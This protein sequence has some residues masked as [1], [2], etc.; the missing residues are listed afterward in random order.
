MKKSFLSAALLMVLALVTFSCDKINDLLTFEIS[1]TQDFKIPATPLAGGLPVTLTLPVPVTNKASET[2]SNNNTKADLVKDVTLSK[3]TLTITDP[4]TEN[5]D[6]LKSI[7]ISIGT[8]QNDKV[9]MAQ[10]DDV[11]RGVTTIEL[12]STNAKLD[13]Y[14]KAPNYTLY[15]EASVR[16]ATTRE[17][18]VKEESRFKVTADP[19]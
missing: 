12:K 14:I 18:T 4:D 7:K 19:L 8:D 10:L 15:T 13:K 9:V 6:F 5:F 11:P 1:D 2:F 16:Q 3:L 17:I